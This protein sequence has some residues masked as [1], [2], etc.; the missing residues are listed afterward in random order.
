MFCFQI[1]HFR[2]ELER[3]QPAIAASVWYAADAGAFDD[4]ASVRGAACTSA[5]R[6]A[7]AYEVLPSISVDNALLEQSDRVA[8]V[9]ATFTWSDV[10][11]WDA[12]AGLSA[13]APAGDE[14]ADAA[15]VIRIDAGGAFVRSEIPIALCGVDDLLVVIENGRALV[16]RAGASQLVKR[17]VDQISERGLTELL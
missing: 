16:C 7:A 9:P 14:G 2:R 13:S 10:G 3:R 15:P 8:V 1:D 12:V 11:S 17:A 5:D 4:P 6:L